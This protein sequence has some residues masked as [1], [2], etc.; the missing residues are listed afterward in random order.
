MMHL[1]QR[2]IENFRNRLVWS[3]RTYFSEEERVG[4]IGINP[5]FLHWP[6]S[7]LICRSFVDCDLFVVCPMKYR[8]SGEAKRVSGPARA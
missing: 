6:L 3:Y 1:F 8:F 4:Y 2:S 5:R 7:R